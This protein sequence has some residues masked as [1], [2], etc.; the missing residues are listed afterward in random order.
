MATI[1]EYLTSE[2]AAL[3]GA[4]KYR[5]IGTFG[6][7]DFSE[8]SAAIAWRDTNHPNDPIYEVNTT[9]V[10]HPFEDDNGDTIEREDLSEVLSN[11]PVA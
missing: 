9:M 2:V 8:L 1:R 6:T 3:V 7:N 10:V 5:V 11:A 4:V